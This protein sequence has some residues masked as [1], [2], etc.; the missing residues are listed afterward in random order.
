[1]KK[2]RAPGREEVVEPE[3]DRE[4]RGPKPRPNARPKARPKR[5]LG[6]RLLRAAAGIAVA[7]V[8]LVFVWER[9]TIV[10]EVRPGPSAPSQPRS[11][12]PGDAAWVVAGALH[13][14]TQRSDDALGTVPELAA[15]ARS[16]GLRFV[17]VTDHQSNDAPQP[18]PR[19]ILEDGVLV[20][21]GQER[22]L[23]GEIGRV[24]V[25]GVD[26]VL[27]LGDSTEKLQV[28]AARPDVL[29]IISHPRS[30]S[31][32]ESWKTPHP[33]GAH[34]WEAFNLDDAMARRAA[35]PGVL[36]HVLGLLVSGP[37]GR[38]SESLLR[39][40]T[41]GFDEPGARGFDSI[42]A[43]A[44]ITALAA[45]D[46]HPKLRLGGRLWPSYEAPL[47]TLANHLVLTDP[48]PATAD[49]A[50]AA[51]RQAVRDGRVFI[52]FGRTEQA[53]EFRAYVARGGVPVAGLGDTTPM[54]PSMTLEG[55]TPLGEAHIL[56]RVVR[57]GEA[58][59]WSAGPVLSWP[60]DRPGAYRL[61]VYRYRASLGSF[62]WNLR[63]WLF[64]NPIRVL[65]T[66]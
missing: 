11:A 56:Y 7:Y 20:L 13:V 41:N 52:S 66:D 54:G 50:S 32:V 30:T 16:R 48:L 62:F 49:S 43:V 33:G 40:Y 59:G 39:L 46:A 63:P 37:L 1:M 34:G 35:G 9:S 36:A 3:A 55:Q 24:L 4:G 8:L 31:E 2:G 51:V 61:E 28:V 57:D 47:G 15:A 42:Y 25:E 14:H 21:F 10:P 65:P 23:D 53:S 45:L 19:P 17:L 5:A 22:G 18:I 64:T 38:S 12:V 44:P 60:V 58:L 26:T 27:F 29:A 6:R